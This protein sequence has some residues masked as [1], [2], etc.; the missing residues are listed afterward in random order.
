MPDVGLVDA[1]ED[2]VGEGDGVDGVVFF[3]TVEGFLFEG[4]EVVGGLDIFVV[5]ACHVF[6]G[7]GEEAAG[8]AACVVDGFAD[9]GVEGLDH[10]ADDDAGGEE[11]AAVVAFFAH[12]E[13]EAFVDLGEG[14]DVGV[15]YGL[16][17]DVVDEVEDVEEVFLGV[18]A[19]AID[20]GEDLADDF[21]A[22]GGVGAGCAVWVEGEVFEVGE[23]V[24]VDE[25][26][27]AIDGAL[28]EFLAFPALG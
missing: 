27:G 5:G 3:A 20:A 22:G 18:D 16:A 8:A 11:L 14:V 15:V 2:E 25:V 17:A 10:G 4:F 23:E 28:L 24:V 6:V 13:Q 12:F 7:L 1:V 9:F 21:L 26:V 19:G